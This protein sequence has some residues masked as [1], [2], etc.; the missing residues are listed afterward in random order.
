MSV[1]PI[2]LRPEAGTNLAHL[3]RPRIGDVWREFGFIFVCEILAVDA[4]TVFLRTKH[5]N[6]ERMTKYRF[7]KWLHYGSIDNTWADVSPSP[8]RGGHG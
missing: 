1:R 8:T 7:R 4:R 2:K 5:T 3:K 6:C